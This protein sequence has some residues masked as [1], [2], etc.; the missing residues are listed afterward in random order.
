[1]TSLPVYPIFRL[2]I[3]HEEC[4]H[5]CA[6]QGPLQL[7]AIV[8]FNPLITFYLTLNTA[9]LIDGLN[10]EDVE[11]KSKTAKIFFSWMSTVIIRYRF[12]IAS[13][14]RPV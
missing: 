10:E 3:I 2:A 9:K 7:Y 13:V 12:K 4:S 6:V 5:F 8:R 14:K 1:M 11:K